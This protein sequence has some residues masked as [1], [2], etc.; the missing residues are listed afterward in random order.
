M[1][2]LLNIFFP[3]VVIFIMIIFSMIL[4]TVRKEGC[5]FQLADVAN[6][7]Y[8]T[9]WF[10]QCEICKVLFSSIACTEVEGEQRLLSN[11]D[12]VCWEGWHQYI[13]TYITIP[14]ILFYVFA[15]PGFMIW[16]IQTQ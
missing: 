15:F 5:K 11:L 6:I 13:V 9:L 1:N 14:G 4:R 16:R 12:I 2:L 3:F 10:L 7:T 8:I